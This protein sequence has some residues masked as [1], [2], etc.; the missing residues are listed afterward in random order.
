LFAG[1]S[2]KTPADG[3]NIN[4]AKPARGL[5]FTV[6]RLSSAKNNKSKAVGCAPVDAMQR[7]RARSR[8]IADVD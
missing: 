8:S 1:K 5:S 3:A 6:W 7:R 2:A 4:G